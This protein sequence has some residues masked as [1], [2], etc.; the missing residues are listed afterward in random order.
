MTLR[1]TPLSPLLGQQVDGVDLEQEIDAATA[2]AI[3]EAWINSGVLLFRGASSSEAAHMRL[4]KVFGELQPA[5][6]AD[7]N[8]GDNPYLMRLAYEPG[9]ETARRKG[10]HVVDGVVR[11]GFLG[12]HW[13]QSFTPQIVRGAVLKMLE[14]SETDG[15]TGFIDAIAAYERL[16]DDLKARIED[17]EV[18]YSFTGAQERNRFGFPD[19]QLLPGR[20]I[21][22]TFSDPSRYNFPPSV[23]PLVIVQQETGRKVLKLS[24]MHSQYILGMDREESDALLH[25]LADH[26]VDPRFAYYHKWQKGDMVVWDNW[27]VLHSARGTPLDQTRVAVRTTIVGDYGYGRYLDTELDRE[28]V[29]SRFDD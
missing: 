20:D 3:R 27:R 1:F 12:W 8:M 7:L 15:E 6:T 4:S 25:R 18:V 26:L 24:P 16:P 13:D 22:G 19:V 29:L 28:L 21:K 17:L 23:H 9:T 5:A 10:I 14:P 11:A 2:Q